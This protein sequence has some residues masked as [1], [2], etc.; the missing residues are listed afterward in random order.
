MFY[1]GVSL[2]ICVC[3][4]GVLEILMFLAVLGIYL[5]LKPKRRAADMCPEFSGIARMPMRQG[6]L[7]TAGL[8]VVMLFWGILLGIYAGDIITHS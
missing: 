6:I 5:L 7:I 2:F 1:Y 4:Y 8:L 3:I